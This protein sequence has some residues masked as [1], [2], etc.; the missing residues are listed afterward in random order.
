M[1]LGQKYIFIK[2][3]KFKFVFPKIYRYLAIAKILRFIQRTSKY[4]NQIFP[5]LKFYGQLRKIYHFKLQIKIEKNKNYFSVIEAKNY[6]SSSRSCSG[7]MCNFDYGNS[8]FCEG[9]ILFI[10]HILIKNSLKIIKMKISV[11]K[12]N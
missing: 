5:T 1:I 12:F 2:A 9:N 4:K 3:Y 11:V 7:G 10:Y 6:C 8:G